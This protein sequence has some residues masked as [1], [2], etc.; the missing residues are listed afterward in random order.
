MAETFGLSLT[1]PYCGYEDPDAWE[2]P[3]GEDTRECPRC[4]REYAYETDRLYTTYEIG[5]DE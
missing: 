4:G 5:G 3:D 2:V 1:C